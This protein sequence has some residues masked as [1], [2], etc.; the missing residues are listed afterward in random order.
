LKRIF[1]HKALIL[2]VTLIFS[3]LLPLFS[4]QNN[5]LYLMHQVPQANL[6]NPAIQ[7]FCKLYIGFPVAGAAHVNYSNTAFTYQ[8]LAGGESWNLEGI[9]EQMHPR[10]VYTV[11]ALVVPI[12]VGYR[13]RGM[14][15]TFHIQE[16]VH[17]WSTVPRDMATLAI[18]GNGPFIGDQ[19]RFNAF[20]P[21]ANHFREYAI[22]VS[23]VMDS[24]L[25]LGAR[26]K[27][28]FG[29]AN[30]STGRSRTNLRTAE[31]NF[32]LLL[33]TDYKY[34]SSFP[35]TLI[36]DDDG[37]I[38]GIEFDPEDLDPATYLLNKQNQGFA[39]DLGAVYKLN[40]K[41][42]LSA[43]L[44]DL[45]FIQWKSDLN[46]V[47]A[48]GIYEYS[49]AD[50][51][52]E[53]VSTAFVQETLDSIVASI[54]VVATQDAYTATTTGQLFLGASYQYNDMISFGVVN[55]NVMYRSKVH[56]SLT[57][58]ASADL[59]Q[60][61]LFTASWS[62]LNNS[63]KNVGLA[64]AYHGKGIQFHAVTDNML[65]FF[66]PFNTRTI[67]LRMGVNFML[68]CPRN[69]RERLIEESYGKGPNGICPYPERPEKKQ[70]KQEKAGARSAK[71]DSKRKR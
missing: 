17:G 43:S 51:Q 35:Y 34:N 23:R 25:T 13:Y 57:L 24:Y 8:D 37:N 36:F 54:D 19:S 60:R 20:R 48:T 1:L 21:G 66:F 18:Q 41:V 55:R 58:S 4:Q 3:V 44:L 63:L 64:V 14:Y 62:Y 59:A 28:L 9:L 71:T 11:E 2:Q 26:A 22:G 12:S 16:R 50:L 61:L 47:R 38:D 65:G 67:N 30:L 5:T 31:D 29:K 68:G 32:G 45:G 49:G 46:N 42:T 10:D 56:S 53:L 7:P 27:L 70:R 40:E 52:S 33:D 15:F 6:L 69:K 39:L